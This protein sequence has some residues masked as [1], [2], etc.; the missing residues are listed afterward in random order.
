MRVLLTGATG[1]IGQ[2]LVRA[3][4]ARGWDV[5]ALVRR[6]DAA[7]AQW[8]KRQ[9]CTLAVGDVTSE[10]GLREAMTGADV[11][12]HNAGVYELGASAAERER[13]DAVNVRGTELVLGAAHAAGVPRTVYVSTVWALG[14]SEA[15][16]VA[17]ESHRHPGTFLSAY[18]RSKVQAHEAALRWRARG[19]PL[20]IAM[21]NGVVGANDH[22]VFGHFL[23]LYLLG[24]MP[25]VAFSGDSVYTFVDVTALAEGIALAAE[26]AEPGADYL[27]CGEP[28][29]IRALFGLWARHPGGMQVRWWA[30]RW[31]MRPQMALMEPLLHAAKVSAFLSRETVD[32][33]AAHLNYSSARARREL[34][35]THPAPEPMWDRIVVRERELMAQRQGFLA[36]LRP[37]AV[38]PH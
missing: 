10:S 21:P 19:L 2:A 6:P 35:W 23:R 37:Q 9:G 29:T 11:V 30:P 38:V 4:R 1:F 20:V 14:P 16:T 12:I 18:E 27:F 32:V 26:R 34:G 3:L 28:T 13:M 22:S 36:R 7:Q 5:T 15:G 33:S 17:D 25:P 8:L 31:F 24:A